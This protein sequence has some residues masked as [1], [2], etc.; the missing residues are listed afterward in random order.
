MWTSTSETGSQDVC[1]IDLDLKCYGKVI[2]FYSKPFT[3]LPDTV[4]LGD[5]RN[6]K[7]IGCIEDKSLWLSIG[8]KFCECSMH[9]FRLFHRHTSLW[10]F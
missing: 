9:R 7:A 10:S 5:P 8:L 4:S 1:S 3:E 6:K 2:K